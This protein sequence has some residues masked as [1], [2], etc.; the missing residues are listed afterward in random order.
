MDKFTTLKA[1]AAPYYHADVDTDEL[2]P[3]R[4]LRKPL[5]RLMAILDVAE[6]DDW[7][8]VHDAARPHPRVIVPGTESTPQQAGRPPSDA[9]VLFNGRDLTGWTAA[10]RCGRSSSPPT[11]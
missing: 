1:V 9:V 11:G 6:P 2:I 4:F 5:A 10:D 8:M 3:H 7:V